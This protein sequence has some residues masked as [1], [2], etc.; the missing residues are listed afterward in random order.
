MFSAADV[1]E[2]IKEKKSDRQR[3]EAD[4]VYEIEVLAVV[5]FSLYRHWLTKASERGA[6]TRIQTDQEAKRLIRQYYA[7]IINGNSASS[8]WTEQ[9][10]INTKPISVDGDDVLDDFTKWCKR[11]DG[12]LPEH[13]HAMLFTRYNLTYIYGKGRLGDGLG[14]AHI[15]KLCTGDQQS[16]IEDSFEED[17]GE[18]CAHEL[19]HRFAIL[20]AALLTK[21]LKWKN[22]GEK[23]DIMC[24]MSSQYNAVVEKNRKI[25]IIPCGVMSLY[26][27]NEPNLAP[28]SHE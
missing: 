23:T 13:D 28:M 16:L 17:V 10:R 5:D 7:L 27:N 21:D 1:T 18:T 6:V 26:D 9:R 20:D 12:Q 25:Q 4:D 15:S 8:S 2:R 11:S 14:V 24:D 19:G 3:R 22:K